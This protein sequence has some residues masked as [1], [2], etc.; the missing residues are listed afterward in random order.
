MHS[1]TLRP[2]LMTYTLFAL[3]IALFSWCFAAWPNPWSR[4]LRS[5]D[6][7]QPDN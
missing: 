5:A 2:Q 6:N 3:M 4:L 1:W 7:E